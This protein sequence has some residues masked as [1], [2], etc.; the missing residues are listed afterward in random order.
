MLSQYLWHPS[1]LFF[2]YHVD[3][4]ENPVFI[5]YIYIFLLFYNFLLFFMLFRQKIPKQQIQRRKQ[6]SF[7]KVCAIL[8]A[9]ILSFYILLVIILY[10]I[11]VN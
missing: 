1:C 8:S 3:N 10:L 9:T 5:L 4:L 6:K 11:F 2:P 7:I